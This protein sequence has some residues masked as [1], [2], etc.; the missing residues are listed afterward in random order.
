MAIRCAHS[1]ADFSEKRGI[2][3][4][5]IVATMEETEVFAVEA[6]DVAMQ[7]IA[8]GVARVKM[9]WDEV[10]AQAK[11]DIAA[12]RKLADDLMAAGH[13]AK[14]PVDMLEKALAAAIASVK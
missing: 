13:I 11:A 10:Y 2:N 9:S 7:A 8:E 12:S 1:I 6:A 3:P 5:N 4:E 14:P